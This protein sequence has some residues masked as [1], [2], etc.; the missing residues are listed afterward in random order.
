[1]LR[2]G[3][4]LNCG[5]YKNYSQL[6][7]FPET[8][9]HLFPFFNWEPVSNA[10]VSTRWWHS[11]RHYHQQMLLAPYVSLLSVLIKIGVFSST[12]FLLIKYFRM[13]FCSTNPLFGNCFFFDRAWTLWKTTPIIARTTH[14]L[15]KMMSFFWKGLTTTIWSRRNCG[16]DACRMTSITM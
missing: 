15:D 1:M 5:V 9:F 2:R 12:W 14:V 8:F 3:S 4:T 6:L 7:E 11:I 13:R 16:L 10:F